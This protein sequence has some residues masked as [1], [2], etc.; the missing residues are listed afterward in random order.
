MD[1]LER[2]LLKAGWRKVGDTL[3]SPDY[4]PSEDEDDEDEDDDEYDGDSE[5]G[6]FACGNP[7]Y[8]LCKASC[9]MFDD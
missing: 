8:P 6:C 7:A 9:P 4:D 3:Y 2:R 5:V 1:S